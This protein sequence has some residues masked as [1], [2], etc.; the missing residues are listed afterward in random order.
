[1]SGPVQPYPMSAP[2]PLPQHYGMP[3]QAMPAPYPILRTSGLCVAG[4]VV[5]ILALLGFWIPFGDVLMGL[6]A[7]G[8][9]WAGVTQSARPGFTGRGMGIAGLVCG[10]LATI[11]ALVLMVLFLSFGFALL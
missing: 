4:M 1:M 2:V 11:P 8:L 6:L 10:I 3:Y 9:S 7:I 5:G